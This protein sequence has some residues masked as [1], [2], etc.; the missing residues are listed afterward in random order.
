M[1][2]SLLLPQISPSLVVINNVQQTNGAV[3][4]DF[5]VVFPTQTVAV[6]FVNTIQS[7]PVVVFS[8]VP[9]FRTAPIVT[10]NVNQPGA[11]LR[12]APRQHASC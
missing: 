7:N 6:N 3:V 4:V 5:G 12:H 10:I 1:A 11:S 9:Q 2:S 8:S